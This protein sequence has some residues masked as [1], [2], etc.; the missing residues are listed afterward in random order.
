MWTVDEEIKN[1]ARR[2]TVSKRMAFSIS[3]HAYII[4][5]AHRKIHLKANYL[6]LDPFAYRVK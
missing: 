3:S 1:L 4:S 2:E 5:P 6:Y